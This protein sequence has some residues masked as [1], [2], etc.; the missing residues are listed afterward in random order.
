VQRLK[1]PWFSKKRELL[2]LDEQIARAASCVD[3]QQT[4]AESQLDVSEAEAAKA[5]LEDMKSTLAQMERS[6]EQLGEPG[7]TEPQPLPGPAGHS[8][9]P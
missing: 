7:P 6:R 3:A 9:L 1:L 5:L 4:L 2:A 8:K